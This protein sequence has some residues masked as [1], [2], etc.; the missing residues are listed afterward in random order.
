M[1]HGAATVD[2]PASNKTEQYHIAE[3][4]RLVTDGTPNACSM[5]YQ[6]SARIAQ[7]MGFWRIQTYILQSEP[8]TSL[9]AAGWGIHHV[10]EHCPTWNNNTRK[11]TVNPE[12]DGKVKVLWFRDLNSPRAVDEK[13]FHARAIR[14]GEQRGARTVKRTNAIAPAQPQ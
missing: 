3:V 1:P 12:S 13:I 5:L 10:A 4:S 14:P 6:A 11:R 9:K 8:G 2:R 7:H